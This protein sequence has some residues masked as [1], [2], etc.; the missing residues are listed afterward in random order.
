VKKTLRLKPI[1]YDGTGVMRMFFKSRQ[2]MNVDAEDL[3]SDEDERLRK[4]TKRL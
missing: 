4:L 2:T 1:N 3:L